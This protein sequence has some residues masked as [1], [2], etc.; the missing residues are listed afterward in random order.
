MSGMGA[1]VFEVSLA[2]ADHAPA[3]QDYR[4]LALEAPPDLLRA[5]APGQFFH[6][7]CPASGA[8]APFLRRPMSIFDADLA[9]GRL[10]FLYKVAGAGTRGLA[11]LRPGDA[12][13]VLG[14]LGRG[15]DIPARARLI[16][17]ARGVGLATLAPLAR[18][19]ADRGSSLLAICSA[20]SPAHLMAVE[21]FRGFGAEVVTVTDAEGNAA[22][23]TLEALI[24]ARIAAQGCERLYTC[25]SNRLLTMLQR[26]AARHGVAGEVALEQQMA[27]GLGM[28]QCCVRPFRRGGET[29]AARVCKE[30]PVFP[31]DEALA[32]PT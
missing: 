17:V 26:V 18:V 28:C 22:P 13:S 7:L 32:W 23:E 9:E 4:L 24:A 19:A 25:G 29:Y 6:L 2:V 12:L 20:R 27:C 10:R 30:G 3:A 5:C 1:R 15:F 21:H 14:P 16:A 8:D 11:T 31:L